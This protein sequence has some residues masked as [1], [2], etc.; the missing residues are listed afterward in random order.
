VR[1]DSHHHLWD[2]TRASYPWLTDDL[3][4]INHTF[5][6]HDLRAVTEVNGIDATVLVQTS[7]S[8]DETIEFLQ[9]EAPVAG[10]IGWVDLTAPDVADVIAQL[11]HGPNGHRLVGIRHQTHDEA[12][13]GWLDRV[14][15]RRGIEA[16]AAASLVFDLLVRTREL[17]A[18]TRLVAALPQCQF[19]LDHL[20]KPPLTEAADSSAMAVWSAALRSLAK[21]SNVAA[22][23]SGLA[24]EADW[25]RWTP[26]DLRPAT[27]VALDAFGPDRLMFASDWPVSLLAASYSTV[28][29]TFDNMF[30][31]LSPTELTAMQGTNAQR[32]YKLDLN[33]RH[34]GATKQ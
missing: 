5:T 14:D 33:Q 16:V 11:M 27:D 10:V 29:E 20:A 15:V 13:A 2:P 23:V 3:A 19:V 18:A 8:V 1:I 26:A 28:V 7:S 9:T 22:K 4:V 12:D 17:P 24:T 21:H 25:H 34:S 32:V 30:S 6:A 31:H